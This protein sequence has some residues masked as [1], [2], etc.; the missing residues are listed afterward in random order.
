MRAYVQTVLQLT[1]FR[2]AV[3]ATLSTAAGFVAAGRPIG[4]SLLTACLGMLVLSAGT[5]A[6]NQCQEVEFDALMPR[7]K[8]RPI[9]SGRMSLAHGLVVSIVLMAAGL[10][11]LW[12][13]TGWI[14]AALGVLAVVWYNGVYTYLKR[15]TAFAVIPGALIGSIPPMIGWAAA[16]GSLS[17]RA[18]VAIAFFFFIWQVP[19]F[20]LLLFK[21]GRQYEQAHLASLTS[22]FTTRQLNRLT[23]TWTSATAVSCLFLPVFGAVR[24]G[25]ISLLLLG[26]AVWLVAKSV[27]LLQPGIEEGAVRSAFLTINVYALMVMLLLSLDKLM[28]LS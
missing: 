26:T 27:K 25:V 20:W 9:P 4:L 1:K 28:R 17:D 11:I 3:M 8:G 13:G 24:S 16:G 12:L 14:T 23:F 19:H 5:L 15:V 6:L 22:T 10:A 2:I 7:T 21:Y 18:I